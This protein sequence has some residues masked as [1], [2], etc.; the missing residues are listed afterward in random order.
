MGI[1]TPKLA[2][3]G[4]KPIE[5]YAPWAVNFHTADLDVA[6]VNQELK[7]AP[8]AGKALYVTHVTM[9]IVDSAAQGY[10]ID[11]Y[12]TLKDGD[13]TALF[14][15]MQMQQQGQGLF[16]KD[17]PENAPLKLTDNKALNGQVK[18]AAGS[19]NT[20]ALVYVEGFTADAQIV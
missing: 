7:A 2:G 6:G 12:I 3:A 20:A 16:K 14:G 17:W 10:L 1:V 9:G 11:N 18:R 4:S 15:P 8:G 13:G 5:R 19:Y